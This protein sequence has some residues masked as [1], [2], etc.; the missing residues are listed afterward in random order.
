VFEFLKSANR[1]WNADRPAKQI[2]SLLA[3]SL[4][5]ARDSSGRL[6]PKIQNDEFVLAYIF[7]VICACLKPLGVTEEEEM[8]ILVRQVYKDIFP[9]NGQGLAE[10]CS[11]KAVQK[12]RAFM[13]NVDVAYTE[14][15]TVFSSGGKNIPKS[16]VDHILANYHGG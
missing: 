11:L 5:F 14:M 15:K 6:D 9:N 2:V 10:V 13:K 4:H 16:L 8:A 3:S 12:D 7:G 1:L